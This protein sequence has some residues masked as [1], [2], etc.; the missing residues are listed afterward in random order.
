[1]GLIIGGR[2]GKISILREAHSFG[3]RGSSVAEQLI[4][5]QQVVGS[6]PIPGSIYFKE[7]RDFPCPIFLS[8]PPTVIKM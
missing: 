3:S 6:T 2:C 8:K 1:M 4:R 5:N 7:L